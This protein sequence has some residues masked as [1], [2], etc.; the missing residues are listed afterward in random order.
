MQ[1]MYAKL[2]P[3]KVQAMDRTYVN[4]VLEKDISALETLRGDMPVETFK[5]NVETVFPAVPD[6]EI[7]DR[8]VVGAQHNSSIGTDGKSKSIQNM[9]EIQ[10]GDKFLLITLNY[11]LND[12]GE[13]CQL[14]N[15]HAAPFDSSPAKAA[16]TQASKIMKTIGGVFLLALLAFLVW[17]FYR[18][19]RKKAVG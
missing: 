12:A 9:F 19:Q 13:C 4:A 1:N 8:S 14:I 2:I 3:E 7:L 15:L 11:S 6:G 18:R 16:L 5:E 17:F 10:K